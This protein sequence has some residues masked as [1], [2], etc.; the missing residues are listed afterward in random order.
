MDTKEQSCVLKR[1]NTIEKY[2]FLLYSNKISKPDLLGEVE[3]FTMTFLFGD[4]IILGG[5]E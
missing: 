1:K 4:F 3:F 5:V 2:I